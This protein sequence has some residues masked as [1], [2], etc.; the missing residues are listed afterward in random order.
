M[1]VLSAGLRNAFSLARQ[2]IEQTLLIITL[3]GLL[4]TNPLT[5]TTADVDSL[6]AQKIGRAD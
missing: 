5:I 2:A 6:L 4:E 3:D 1:Q